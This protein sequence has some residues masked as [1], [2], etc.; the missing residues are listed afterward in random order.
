MACAA[1]W[2]LRVACS[3]HF[4]VQMFVRAASHFF[5]V[6][7]PAMGS[8][9]Q[10]LA[11]VLCLVL[12]EI[13]VLFCAIQSYDTFR[14]RWRL[15][16]SA[17]LDRVSSHVSNRRWDYSGRGES[18]C[19]DD[20]RCRRGYDGCSR[21]GSRLL[22][23]FSALPCSPLFLLLHIVFCFPRALTGHL[24]LRCRYLRSRAL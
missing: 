13:F 1:S 8:T 9:Q 11:D 14:L 19:L 3:R 23:P 17:V 16:W 2:I 18:L 20:V 12:N 5:V 7:I 22:R 21:R 15:L 6:P 10:W 24:W 4:C